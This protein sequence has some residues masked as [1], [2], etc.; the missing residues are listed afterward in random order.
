MSFSLY[1]MALADPFTETEIL[2]AF[3]SHVAADR[4]GDLQI[5]YD[6]QNESTIFCDFTAAR[7]AESFSINRPCGDGRL[8][9]G[10][11]ELLSVRPS[12]LTYPDEE[13]VCIVATE[14][15]ASAVRAKHPELSDA[16]RICKTAASLVEAW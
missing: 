4:D 15:F 13:L 11:H 12:F 10:L 5:R 16:V 3:G 9:V 7:T 14:A 1:V 6:D 8:F 2:A